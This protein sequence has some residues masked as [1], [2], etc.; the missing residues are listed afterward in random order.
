MLA[1]KSAD[2]M[3]YIIIIIIIIMKQA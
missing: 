3:P 2:Y 1:A